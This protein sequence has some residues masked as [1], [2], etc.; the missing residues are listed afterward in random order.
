MIDEMKVEIGITGFG[1]KLDDDLKSDCW[2]NMPPELLTDILMRIEASESDWPDRKS[3]VCC[4]AVCRSWRKNM[5]EI[6]KCPE[7]SG[8]LT[9]PSSLKQPGSVGSLTQCFIKRNRNTQTYTLY[10]NLTEASNDEGKFLFAAKRFRRTT[11]TDYIISLNADDISKGSSGYVGKL[12]SNFLGTKFRVYDARPTNAALLAT[13]CHSSRLGSIKRVSPKIPAGNYPISNI[14]YEVNNPGTR[15]PRQMRCVM[16][17]IPANAIEPRV[18]PTPTDFHVDS[19]SSSSSSSSSRSLSG[20]KSAHVSDAQL[21]ALVLKNKNP[22]WHQQ[23]QCWCL[24][25]NGRVTVASVKNFQLV[26]CLEDENGSKEHEKIVLEFGK[27]GKDVFTMD[28]QYPI[29]AFEAFA[30]CLSSF[31]TKI[32]CE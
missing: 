16:N 31:D 17:A 27:I 8:C 21:G 28:Y 20:S 22:R 11:C 3:V 7:V 19:S 13:K 30:I 15:G 10:L 4:A 25:F 32:T 14:S 24:N 9:F 29:S 23:L 6:V 26:A 12:R 5:K 18:G 1:S 2:A